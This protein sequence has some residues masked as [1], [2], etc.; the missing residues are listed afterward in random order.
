MDISRLADILKNKA[1]SAVEDYSQLANAYPNLKNFAGSLVGNIERNVPTQADF[2]SPQAMSQWSQS[3]ALNAPMGLM[4]AGKSAKLAPLDKYNEAEQLIEEKYP[5]FLNVPVG[6]DVWHNINRDIHAKTGIHYDATGK[7]LHEF[8]D[9]KSYLY[10]NGPKYGVQ[11]YTPLGE[12][13]PHEE[14]YKNYQI[15]K[16]IPVSYRNNQ[17][18]TGGGNLRIGYDPLEEAVSYEIQM[19]QAGHPRNKETFVHEMQHV[20]QDLEGLE[21]GG[22]HAEIKKRLPYYLKQSTLDWLK[23]GD[24]YKNLPWEEQ[25]AYLNEKASNLLGNEDSVYQRLFGEAQARATAR[26]MNMTQAERDASYPYDSY[27][28]PVKDLIVRALL[29]KQ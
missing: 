27:D 16:D 7:P 23:N 15:L 9:D 11:E 1:S 5:H 6:S 25:G 10:L 14:A 29:R 28:I 3:A 12:T 8:S 20:I 17:Y 24:E 22:S 26:R 18:E 21:S 4:F 2:E 19:N 13:L